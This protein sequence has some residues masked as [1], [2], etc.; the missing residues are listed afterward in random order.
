M[1]CLLRD[2]IKDEAEKFLKAVN[3]ELPE[4][5]ELEFEGFF[6]RGFFVTKKRYALIQEG[7]IV[8]KGLELVRR[9][10]APVARKTQEKVLRAILEDGSPKKAT[11][12]VRDVIEDIK[13]GNLDLE[14][15]VI[16]TQITRNPESYQQNAPHVMAAKKA[17]ERGRKVV[18]GSIMR[19]VVVK[20]KSPISQRAEPVEDVDISDYDPTYYIENQVLPAISR[21]IEA[22]GYSPSEVMHQERQSSLDAF[23]N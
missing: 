12:I 15:L 18:R 6:E 8:V 21:I 1:V 19:Y 4:G 22:I 3:Q 11:K 23:F 13:K 7:K 9:D 14:D 16:N 2:T 10:W 20:G 17:I 5:M